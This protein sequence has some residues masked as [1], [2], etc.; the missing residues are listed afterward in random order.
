MTPLK[1]EAGSGY[2][3]SARSL[4]ASSDR[5]RRQAKTNRSGFRLRERRDPVKRTVLQ[6]LQANPRTPTQ[7]KGGSAV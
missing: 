1:G 5:G 3:R 6:P 2:G 7:G 4:A